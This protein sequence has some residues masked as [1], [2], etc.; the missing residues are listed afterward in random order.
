MTRIFPDFAYGPAPRDGC[1]WDET[2][3]LPETPRL[4]GNLSADVAIIGAGF[5]GLNAAI[6]IAQAGASVV[7]LDANSPG[8]GASGRNGGFC[9]LGGGMLEDD[10]IDRRWDVAA[11]R[12][13]REAEMAA[14]EQVSVFLAETRTE[15]DVAIGGETWLA[16]RAKDMKSIDANAARIKENYG[17]DAVVHDASR[18][19]ENGM[20]GPFHGGLT[21]PI[22]FGLNP[23]KYIAGLLRAAETEGAAVRGHAKVTDVEKTDDKWVLKTERGQI[24]ARQVIVATNGYSSENIPNWLAGRYMPT[25]SNVLVTRPLTQSELDAQG[26]GTHQICYDSRNLLHYFRL[27]PDRRFLFGMRGGLGASKQ[28]EKRARAAAKR[29]FQNMFP[30]WADVEL[31]HSWSG[32]VCLARNR[33]PFVGQVP[34]ESGLWAETVLQWVVSLGAYSVIWFW[35]TRRNYIHGFFANHW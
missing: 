9:C 27:L 33:L 31:E 8:W 21:L 26:W 5:T 35:A 16:H 32:M 6:R 18:L 28:S 19:A 15:A 10:E 13:W 25:Q 11:R 1:F 22:G 24:T 2:C 12:E 20:K 29:D 3:K 14:V 4:A 17:V 30:A 34:G 7:V 23:R